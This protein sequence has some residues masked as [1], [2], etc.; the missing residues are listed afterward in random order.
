MQFES[1][2]AALAMGGHGVYVWTV[3]LV[4]AAVVAGLLVVPHLSSR[5]LLRDLRASAP[6]TGQRDQEARVPTA[7]I[8]EVHNAPGT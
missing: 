8:E 5:R 6:Q 7:V 4:S 1:V 2:A 3:A